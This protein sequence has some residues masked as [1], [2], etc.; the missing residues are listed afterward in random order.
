[1]SFSL[2]RKTDYGL[3]ALATLAAEAAGAGQPLSAR[4]I[5]EAYNLPLPLL[6]NVLKDLHRAGIVCSRRGASGGYHLCK[7]P[8]KISLLSIIEAIEGP[9]HAAVC[10]SEEEIAGGEPCT[11]CRVQP[12]CPITTPMQRLDERVREFLTGLSLRDV[13][14]D[15][16]VQLNTPAHAAREDRP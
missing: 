6:M 16:P 8:G 5:A 15:P 12:Q 3:V 13:L 7:D 14:A 2:T 1:M 9:V 4:Q 11:A 10:C